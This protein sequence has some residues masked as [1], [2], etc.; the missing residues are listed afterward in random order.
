VRVALS[1]EVKEPRQLWADA[2]QIW[3]VP[4]PP[5]ARMTRAPLLLSRKPNRVAQVGLPPEG[6]VVTEPLSQ[7]ASGR[8]SCSSRV[9]R[10]QRTRAPAPPGSMP[11][12]TEK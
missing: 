10:L 8:Q 5:A 9:T 12:A 2:G 4:P 1:H 3:A 6:A 7:E 11:M